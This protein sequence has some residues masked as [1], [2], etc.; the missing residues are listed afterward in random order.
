MDGQVIEIA[1]YDTY[2]NKGKRC[3][4]IRMHDGTTIKL[5]VTQPTDSAESMPE[6]TPV[7]NI[8]TEKK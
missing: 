8:W 7:S 3:V 1:S 6:K 5:V 2:H 4:A